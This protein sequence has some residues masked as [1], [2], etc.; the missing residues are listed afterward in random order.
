[1]VE[2]K[3]GIH[4]RGTKVLVKPFEVEEK[5]ASGII[6][7]TESLKR[8]QMAQVQAV[9]VAIGSLAYNDQA[10]PWC[11]VG[12]KVIFAKYAGTIRDG[13]DGDE[14]RL[15]QDLDIVAVLED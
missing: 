15:I 12:E 14:Y 8:D 7:H 10:E 4:P 2:N 11:K 9:V 13:K 5:T 3:S 6:L 1:M